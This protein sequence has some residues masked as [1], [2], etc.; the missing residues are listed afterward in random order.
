MPLM[1]ALRNRE[2]RDHCGHGAPAR[3]IPTYARV[4]QRSRRRTA[5]TE[6][7]CHPP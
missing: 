7:I 3:G 5:E 1:V 6:Y 2:Q 4:M